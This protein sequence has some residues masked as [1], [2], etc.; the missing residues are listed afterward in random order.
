MVREDKLDHQN[1]AVSHLGQ[2]NNVA[3]TAKIFDSA[4]RLALSL[5]PS[6]IS[7]K[8]AIRPFGQVTLWNLIT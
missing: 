8:L 6:T 1:T 5:P 7:D 3:V 4:S 2:I